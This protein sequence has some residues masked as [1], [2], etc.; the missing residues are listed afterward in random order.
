MIIGRRDIS[1]RF[2][3]DHA[4]KKITLTRPWTDEG[5]EALRNVYEVALP[6]T[7]PWA[8]D[9]LMEAL[10]GAGAFCPVFYDQV[11]EKLIGA[12]PGSVK[13]IASFGVGTD[14]IDMVAA[15]AKGL[16]VT[17]TPEVLSEDTADITLGLMIATLRG[18]SSGVSGIALP[19]P[20]PALET[21]ALRARP[22]ST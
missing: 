20:R 21:P 10:S 22:S 4:M 12:L 19:W 6:K 3:Y 13:I 16:I 2:V 8:W 7:D 5:M 9:D 15:K 14:H 1:R 17:N 11:D 18:F